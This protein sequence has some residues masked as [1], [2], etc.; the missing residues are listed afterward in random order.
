L[1]SIPEVVPTNT[2]H[3]DNPAPFPRDDQAIAAGLTWWGAVLAARPAIAAA[4]AARDYAQVARRAI[5]DRLPFA[6][7]RQFDAAEWERW[8]LPPADPEA[9]YWNFIMGQEAEITESGNDL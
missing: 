2:A 9:D 1:V 7:G 5:A 4:W 8:G 6:D 3:A